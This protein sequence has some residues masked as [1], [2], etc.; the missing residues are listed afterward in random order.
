MMMYKNPKNRYFD[1]LVD[2]L[3]RSDMKIRDE[4]TTC[5][6]YWLTE[7]GILGYRFNPISLWYFVRDDKILTIIAN[8]SNTPWGE[9]ILYEVPVNNSIKVWKQLHVSPFNPPRNQYYLFNTNI[10]KGDTFNPTTLYWD[11][12]LFDKDDSLVLSANMKLMAVQTPK[13]IFFNFL[14]I[15]FRIYYQALLLWM[16]KFPVY[17]HIARDSKLEK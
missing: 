13:Y 6:I 14:I 3:K 16:G 7:P 11:I 5:D 12:S 10:N 8:V 9:E 2:E 17:N 15:I 1:N 4:Y